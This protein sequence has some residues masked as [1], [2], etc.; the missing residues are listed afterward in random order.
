MGACFF[1]K[2]LL[3]FVTLREKSTPKA[4]QLHLSPDF[5]TLE[6]KDTRGM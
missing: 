2:E 4:K 3:P 1:A 5:R 6:P